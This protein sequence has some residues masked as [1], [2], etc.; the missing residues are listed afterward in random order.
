MMVA[1]SFFAWKLLVAA[2]TQDERNHLRR[3]RTA[4]RKTL[5]PLHDLGDVEFRNRYR[6]TKE[7]FLFLCHELEQLTSLKSTQQISLQEKV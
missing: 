2:Q 5:N 3:K 7:A 6:F 4:F 1:R